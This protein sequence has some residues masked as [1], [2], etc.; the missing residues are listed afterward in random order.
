MGKEVWELVITNIDVLIAIVI[1]IFITRTICVRGSITCCLTL[2]ELSP[3]VFA[4]V[5][6]FVL[7]LSVLFDLV[8]LRVLVQ[9]VAAHESFPTVPALEVLL[10][11][12]GSQVTLELI[13]ACKPFLAVQPPADERTLP[14]VPSEVSFQV[15]RFPVLLP[16]PGVV[17]N[18]HPALFRARAR[19]T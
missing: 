12:V 10:T 17:A 8:C 11:C 3:E 18:M 16:T 5:L 7:V 1:K 13:G 19:V 15:R 6:A 2:S 4:F 9:V 14:S